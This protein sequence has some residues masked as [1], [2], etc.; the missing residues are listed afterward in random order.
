MNIRCLFPL[1]ICTICV[2]TPPAIP[3]RTLTVFESSEFCR[4][5][6][7]FQKTSWA[8]KAG[9]INNSYTFVD[10]DNGDSRPSL[11]VELPTDGSKITSISIGW[12][13]YRDKV[14][15]T[16]NKEDQIRMLLLFW[17]TSNLTSRVV[18]FAKS[19]YRTNCP[20]SV[21]LSPKTRI[22]GISVQCGQSAGDVYLSWQ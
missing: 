3:S 7:K 11:S 16:H 21:G 18:G 12:L 5:M 13:P 10:P 22:G 8:L 6:G 9:G 1:I 4:K 19:R 14:K 20:N 15:W 2:A 17:G